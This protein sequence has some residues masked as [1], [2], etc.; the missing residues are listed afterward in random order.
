M[1]II[2][3]RE[4]IDEDVMEDGMPKDNSDWTVARWCVVVVVM[5]AAIHFLTCSAAAVVEPMQAKGRG[6]GASG[7]EARTPSRTR[8]LLAS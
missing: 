1:E 7:R 8:L 3:H 5:V 6:S 2:S 4:E